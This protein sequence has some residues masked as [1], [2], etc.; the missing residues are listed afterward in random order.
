[1]RDWCVVVV[2]VVVVVADVSCCDV[3]RLERAP[4]GILMSPDA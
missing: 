2:V 4:R 3:G 1:M